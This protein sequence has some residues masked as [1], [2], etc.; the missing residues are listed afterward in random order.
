VWPFR[1]SCTPLR[2]TSRSASGRRTPNGGWNWWRGKIVEAAP[3]S[4]RNSVLAA[5]I[6]GFLVGYVDERDLG[7]VTGADGGFQLGPRTVRLPDAAFISKERAGGLEGSV[8]GGAPDLAVEVISESET[9]R[10][11]LDKARAYLDAGAQMVWTVYPDAQV[12]DVYRRSADGGMI[13]DTIGADGTLSG[14]PALPGFT[15]PLADLF[16]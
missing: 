5:R 14:L 10:D 7:Y 16:R 15:L 9:P 11:V 13:V 4:V 1:R 12:V 3:S 8:F 2:N 6:A